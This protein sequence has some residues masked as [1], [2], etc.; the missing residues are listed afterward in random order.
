MLSFC[1]TQILTSGRSNRYWNAVASLFSRAPTPDR[2]PEA[3]GSAFYSNKLRS[4]RAEIIGVA[5]GRNRIQIGRLG[6]TVSSN[7][8]FTKIP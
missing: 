4:Y 5:L 7:Q 3:D 8:F 1:Y 6:K 2:A